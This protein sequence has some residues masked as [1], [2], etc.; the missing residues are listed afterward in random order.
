MLVIVNI[1]LQVFFINKES[2]VRS[3]ITLIFVCF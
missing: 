3:K 2:I 1:I